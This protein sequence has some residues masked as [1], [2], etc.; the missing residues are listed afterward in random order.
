MRAEL[1]LPGFRHFRGCG[2]GY[3]AVSPH[4]GAPAGMDKAAA[5]PALLTAR[6][7]ATYQRELSTSAAGSVPRLCRRNTG[8]WSPF[9]TR[10]AGEVRTFLSTKRTH[11]AE[12]R[13]FGILPGP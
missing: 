11:C 10:R 1:L 8:R 4:R 9:A 12:A 2:S 7:R 3:C 5:L 13:A 6:R